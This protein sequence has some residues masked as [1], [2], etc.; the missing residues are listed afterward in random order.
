MS[1]SMFVCVCVCCVCVCV[2]RV[3][4]MCV[5]VEGTCAAN[6]KA[7]DVGWTDNGRETDGWR[8]ETGDR[9]GVNRL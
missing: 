7:D 8:I 5:C 3:C 9:L 6:R 4:V 1:M 2:V